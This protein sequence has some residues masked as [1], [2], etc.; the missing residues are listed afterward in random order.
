VPHYEQKIDEKGQNTTI[1][2][3]KYAIIQKHTKRQKYKQDKNTNEEI[4]KRHTINGS[5][6]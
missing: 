5:G 3:S 2:Y 6:P 1:Q 4:T